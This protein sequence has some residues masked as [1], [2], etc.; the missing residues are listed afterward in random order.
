MIFNPL[1]P[2]GGSLVKKVLCFAALCVALTVMTG[3]A[4]AQQEEF[5]LAH[6]GAVGVGAVHNSGKVTPGAPKYC[7]PCLLYGG[8]WDDT[9]ANWVLFAN[10]D[11]PAFGGPIN[12]FSPIPVPKGATWTVTSIFS[13]TNFI[14]INKMDPA[15]PEWSINKGVKSGS[16]GKVV[17]HGQTKGTAKATGR[18]A[19]SGDGPVVEYTIMVKL[20]KA[21]VL[22]AGTYWETVTPPCTNTGDSSCASALFYESDT[23]NTAG[24]AR[25]AHSFGKEPSGS[26]FQNGAGAG[27]NWQQINGTYCSG[28][29]YQTYACNWMSAGVVGT[30]KN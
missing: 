10:G 12:L 3:L 9:S 22:K 17:A 26:N 25:G 8:D 5:P 14:G 7:S 30:S 6:V 1:G 21:V 15:K 2:S 28:F 13:N 16:G 20:P 24:T 27:I 23:F 29:G 11:L 18:S 4:S 19:T